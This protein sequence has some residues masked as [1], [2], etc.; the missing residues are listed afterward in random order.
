MKVINTP[1]DVALAAT[2]S[3]EVSN[4]PAPTDPTANPFRLVVDPVM[5]VRL[6]KALF[7]LIES[8]DQE[9][10]RYVADGTLALDSYKEYIELFAR[11]LRE[12]MNSKE[13]ITYLLESCGF[14]INKDDINLYPET[15]WRVHR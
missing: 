1:T 9:L 5:R 12:T 13:G 6:R 2:T 15:R 11:S 10:A 4:E 7:D 3:F 14:Q 8:H